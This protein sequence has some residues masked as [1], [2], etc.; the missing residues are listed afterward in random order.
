M[1]D[2][3][4]VRQ[5]RTTKIPT[6]PGVSGSDKAK[7]RPSD[8]AGTPAGGSRPHLGSGVLSSGTA[9]KPAAH[10]GHS[11]AE[12]GAGPMSGTA[13]ISTTPAPSRP[14]SG[15][16]P[17]SSG[18]AGTS[19]TIG[20]KPPFVKGGTPGTGTAGTHS[21]GARSTPRTGMQTPASGTAGTG[22]PKGAKADKVNRGTRRL[23]SDTAFPPVS[24]SQTKAPKSRR[25]GRN[26]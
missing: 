13:G 10:I 2:R 22:A 11:K 23:H 16:R 5:D 19:H 17:A 8:T 3:Q 14:A 15:G 24:G 12:Q 26:L 7:L 20:S 25:K 9:G 4:P 21:S 1:R 18:I 6:P